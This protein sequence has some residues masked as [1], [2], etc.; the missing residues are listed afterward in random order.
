MPLVKII[1]E[2]GIVEDVLG[3]PEGYTWEVD[4]QTGSDVGENEDAE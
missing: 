4:D 1:I 2:E 3:L